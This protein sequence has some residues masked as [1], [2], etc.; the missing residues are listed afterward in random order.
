MGTRAVYTFKSHNEI[1]HVYKHWDGY[2]EGAAS[3]FANAV[4][5]AWQG[6]RFEASDFAAAFIAGNKK[7]GGG[8]IYF[9]KG[10]KAHGDLEYVYEVYPNKK[11]HERSIRAYEVDY[12][13]ED[14]LTKRKI[15]DGT[16]NEFIFEHGAQDTA[17][18]HSN[19]IH[20]GK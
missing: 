17:E 18:E 15:F 3:F 1:Y 9:T 2:P 8:D 13:N 11:T 6:D 19:F 16:M 10:P 20:G 4:Q 12:N 5:Y 14:K 7:K